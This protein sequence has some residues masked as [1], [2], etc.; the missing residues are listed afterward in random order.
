MLKPKFFW[1]RSIA[2]LLLLLG[3]T[4]KPLWSQPKQA[5]PVQTFTPGVQLNSPYLINRGSETLRLEV[6]LETD[7]RYRTKSFSDSSF[8]S[9]PQK[10]TEPVTEFGSM[11]GADKE[12]DGVRPIVNTETVVESG[13]V[14]VSR[15]RELDIK[16][17]AADNFD[18]LFEDNCSKT[19]E[20]N[21]F[22][23]AFD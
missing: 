20:E 14:S 11:F 10:L 22:C 13:E 23:S 7:K 4:G 12:E 5:I 16:E 17:G 9:E 8:R 18:A 6:H 19:S 1:H 15:L 21:L 2:G 3:I